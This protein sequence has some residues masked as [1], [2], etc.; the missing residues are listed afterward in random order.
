TGSGPRL[1]SV[2]GGRPGQTRSAGP[3]RSYQSELKVALGSN[4]K[5]NVKMEIKPSP[6]MHVNN[7]SSLQEVAMKRLLLVVTILASGAM[8]LNAA[9]MFVPKPEQSQASV[10]ES[11]NYYQHRHYYHRP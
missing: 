11:V 7:A 10:V 5:Q 3:G 6:W 2:A 4:T 1:R 9:P 8:P